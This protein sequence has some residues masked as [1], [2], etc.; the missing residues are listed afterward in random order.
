MLSNR[1]SEE[2]WELE[3]SRV[4]F[5]NQSFAESPPGPLRFK[6][7]LLA[8]LII[9]PW[10][11]RAFSGTRFY[12]DLIF[13]NHIKKQQNMHKIKVAVAFGLYNYRFSFIRK[14]LEYR[15]F[16]FIERSQFFSIFI[17]YDQFSNKTFCYHHSFQTNLSI[18]LS[19]CIDI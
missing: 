7:L 11:R 6:P 8:A 5:A 15:F 18:S 13:K 4:V 19:T 9:S 12:E 3:K 17:V 14:C 16:V 2:S 10:K 1:F